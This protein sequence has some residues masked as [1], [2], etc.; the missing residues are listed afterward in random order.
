MS[1]LFRFDSILQLRRRQRDEVG[2]A[3]GKANE[4]IQRIDLEIEEIEKERI[5]AA[6]K[7]AE[8]RVGTVSVDSLLSTGRYDLQLQADTN[9]L[10]ETRAKL[11]QELERRQAALQVAEAELKRFEKLEDNEKKAYQAELLRREQLESDD[12]NSRRF[13]IQRQRENQ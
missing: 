1:F 8:G 12:A 2:S 7:A 10:Q 5:D 6:K 11:V 9:A 3:V 13:T 4:A